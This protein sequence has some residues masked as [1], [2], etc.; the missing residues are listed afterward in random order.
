MWAHDPLQH[1]IMSGCYFL[2]LSG[3]CVKYMTKEIC[4][5]VWID[6]FPKVHQ[7]NSKKSF[8][9]QMT[10]TMNSLLIHGELDL[11]G[12]RSIEHSKK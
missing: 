3:A 6:I 9:F 12:A 10:N 5:D 2:C 11:L 1:K 8:S 4:C 7:H